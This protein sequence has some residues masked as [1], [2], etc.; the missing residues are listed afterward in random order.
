MLKVKQNWIPGNNV[1]VGFLNF[2]VIE[3]VSTPG[4]FK[5]DF[6][7]LANVKGVFYSFTPHYGLGNCNGMTL[8]QIRNNW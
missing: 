2:T 5:P 8:E 6:Y 7:I 4:D 1:K 3:K